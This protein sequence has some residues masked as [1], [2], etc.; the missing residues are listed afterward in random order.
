M[1][2]ALLS[3]G[4]RAIGVEA[5]SRLYDVWDP[6]RGRWPR[7]PYRPPNSGV[8]TDCTARYCTACRSP[9]GSGVEWSVSGGG[10]LES[11]VKMNGL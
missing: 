9:D 1:G 4:F 5:M 3:A 10:L 6:L 7:A 11:A 2:A 8:I